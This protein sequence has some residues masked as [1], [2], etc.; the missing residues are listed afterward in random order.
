MYLLFLHNINN[1]VGT[2]VPGFQAISS[3]QVLTNIKS[4]NVVFFYP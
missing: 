4:K 2:I 3:P 1:M